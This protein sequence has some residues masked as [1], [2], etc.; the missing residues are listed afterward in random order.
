M[1]CWMWGTTQ[2][3]KG[4]SGVGT[5]SEEEVLSPA[6]VSRNDHC[7]VNTIRTNMQAHLKSSMC[8]LVLLFVCSLYTASSAPNAAT[9]LRVEYLPSPVLGMDQPKYFRFFREAFL[10]SFTSPR[11]SWSVHHT[12][13]GEYQSAYQVIQSLLY[14]NWLK[15]TDPSS[16]GRG[17]SSFGVG[18]RNSVLQRNF[19][20]SLQGTLLYCPFSP[21]AKGKQLLSDTQY[22]WRVTSLRSSLVANCTL[23][24]VSW[25]DSNKNKAPVSASATFV[26]GL[27]QQSEWKAHWISGHNMFRKG[28][29]IK[30]FWP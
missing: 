26:T 16:S 30:F 27:F 6:V 13:R 5:S 11:F 28:A 22:Y 23:T 10:I 19:T 1:E 18:L 15:I 17:L 8:L 21:S 14:C 24:K 29:V 9:N 2:E 7:H 3:L 4:T 20:N 25:W 12:E